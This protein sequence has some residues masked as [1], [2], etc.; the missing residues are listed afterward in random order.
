MS[1]KFN[2]LINDKELL[3]NLSSLKYEYMTDIQEKSLPLL[4]KGE[5]LIAQAKTG[6]GKTLSFCLPIVLNLNVKKFKI[7]S[8]ILAP[9]RELADQ[10]AKELRKVFRH[11]HNVKVLSLCGGVP[12]KPQVSSLYHGAHIIVGTPGRVIKHLENNNLSCEDVNY[13]VLDEADKMLDMGFSDDINKIKEFLP[14]DR[15]SMLFSASYQ[16]NIQ[17]LAKD[18]LKADASFIQLEEVER[19]INQV[20]YKIQN[21]KDICIKDLIKKY[22]AKSTLIFVNRKDKCEE[23]ADFLYE[24]GMDVLTLHSNLEQKERNEVLTL[25]SNKSYPILIASDVA[26]R[27]IDIDDIDLIINYD[28]ALNKKTH[29]HRIG[30]TARA[31]KQG[32]AVSLYSSYDEEMLDELKEEFDNLVFENIDS[33]E[34]NDYV[35]DSE[36]RTIFINGGKK[37]KIRAG[38]ILGALCAGLNMDKSN[39][40]DIT[41]FDFCSYVAIKKEFL[42]EALKGLEKGKIKNKKFRVYEK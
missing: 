33:L 32:T 1:K 29:Q 23:L 10:I 11:I 34:S 42:K 36:F 38:D 19:K 13:F 20:F 8:L 30:R 14:Q 26:A 9:T 31:G 40:G 35:I 5:D 39:I 16:E 27:G 17:L 7:Q 6:S 18:F 21:N 2:T 28:M 4:L 24:D 12:Y 37:H 22:E 41:I 15:Q 25:F 3:I